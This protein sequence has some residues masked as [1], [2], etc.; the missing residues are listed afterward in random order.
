M[1][2][3]TSNPATAAPTRVDEALAELAD[4]PAAPSRRQRVRQELRFAGPIVGLVLGIKLLLFWLGG[5]VG[6]T[7]GNRGFES[8]FERFH[9]WNVWDA[10]QYLGVAEFG[11][12]TVGE[13]E[14]TQIAFFPGYPMAV[15]AV[16]AV[17][18]GD[19]LAAAFVTSAIASITAA[20]LLAQLVRADGGDDA[21]ATRAAWFLLIFPTAYFLHL[22]YTESLFLTFVLGAFVAARTGHWAT[23]GIVGALAAMTRLNGILLIPA[24]AVEAYLQ[25]RRSGRFDRRSLWILVTGA[26]LAFYLAINQHYFGDPFHFQQVQ[27]ENWSKHFQNPIKTV[28]G[29]LGGYDTWTKPG[30]GLMVI[31]MELGFMTLGLVASLLAWRY[32]RPSYAVWGLLNVLLF[33]STSWVQSTPRYVLTVFPIFLLLAKLR[34]GWL[35]M[36]ASAWSM[37][38]FAWLATLFA[39]G[40]WAF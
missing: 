13:A 22:P 19:F 12:R 21:Q 8:F 17:I 27:A 36:L 9:M 7:L 39:L 3:T 4:P 14:R 15:R 20:V 29:M 25:Y 23:A 33:A 32:L 34:P 10:Q 16:H 37:A 6:E 30:E 31:S 24:L 38:A 5:V 28:T 26:G 40:H 1:S 2:A 18:P 35:S 11:Y